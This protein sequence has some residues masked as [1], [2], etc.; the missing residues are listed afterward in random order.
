MQS[1]KKP[2]QIAAFC[3]LYSIAAAD[4]RGEA[5]FGDSFDQATDFYRRTLIG[6]G[7]PIA[8]L[9]FPLLGEP[10]LDLLSVH[11]SVAPEAKFAPGA[12]YGHQAMFDWFAEASSG[13][14]ADDVSVGL[15]LD[16]SAGQTQTVGV[17]LQQRQHT[18]LV[19][20]FLNSIGEAARA[21][22]YLDVLGLMPEGW[23]PSYVGLFPGR[24]GTPLR[25][26]GYMGR[27]E[28]AH[29][30]TDPAYLGEQF[31]Q[32]GFT[33][34]DDDM[35][36]RCAEFMRLAPSIDFQFDIMPDG[37]LGDT[38]GLSLSFNETMPREARE[39]MSSGYG[40]QLMHV[41]QGWGLADDRWKAIAG[42]AFARHVGVEGEDGNEER[43]ALCVRFNYA[44]VKFSSCEPRPAKFYLTCAAGELIA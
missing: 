15:E 19:A 14:L 41:L 36:D 43:F 8:H 32:I 37:S 28:H 6:D 24:E 40:A 34:F 29:C 10:C 16:L 25:I 2:T 35:L 4:G 20:P 1:M 17:Y 26:G 18:Q 44:K 9:E 33:A 23:P 7:Y 27:A 22:S 12:G 39:C 3:A 38:F 30:A 5:L 11:A 21:Q 42:A 31:R 13:E